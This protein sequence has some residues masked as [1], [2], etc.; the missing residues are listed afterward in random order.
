[1]VS[2]AVVG[3][4][5]YVVAAVFMDWVAWSNFVWPLFSILLLAFPMGCW[6]VMLDLQTGIITHK[7]VGFLDGTEFVVFDSKFAVTLAFVSCILCH[8][9]V[10]LLLLCAWLALVWCLVA[11]SW[12]GYGLVALFGPV[13]CLAAMP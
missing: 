13:W 11:M 5:G 6:F 9:Y 7:S 2:Y 1:M 4:F 3:E 12:S 8:A 10:L